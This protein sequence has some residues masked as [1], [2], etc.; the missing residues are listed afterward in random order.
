MKIYNI[1]KKEASASLTAHGTEYK[2]PKSSGINTKGK[3]GFI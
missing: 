2:R 1:S 3:S